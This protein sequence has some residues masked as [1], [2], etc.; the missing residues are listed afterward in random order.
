MGEGAVRWLFEKRGVIAVNFASQYP[1]IKTKEE[2]E[3][4][5]IE[6]GAEDFRWY[7]EDLEVYT[8][9]ENLEKVRK[10]LEEK[11]AK[12]EGASLDW[13]A[14]EEILAD[15]KTKS[16]C[17]KLFEELDNNDAVQEIYSNINM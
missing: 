14:K 8:K 16:A 4:L 2:L 12:T 9:P 15:E 3:L 1:T 5:A 11:G 17:Q 6:A 10:V 7:D 13:V